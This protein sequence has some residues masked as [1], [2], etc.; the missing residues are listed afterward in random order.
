MGSNHFY[1]G[2]IEDDKG[3]T[4][5]NHFITPPPAC[6]Q[7]ISLWDIECIRTAQMILGE[8]IWTVPTLTPKKEIHSM[9][10]RKN[11]IKAQLQY[12]DSHIL[13]ETSVYMCLRT[14]H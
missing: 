7:E 3:G 6:I 1:T 2:N 10:A 8:N 5:I 4:A 14:F 9:H 13:C 11:T 12:L